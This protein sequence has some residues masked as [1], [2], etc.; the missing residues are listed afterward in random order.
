MSR[1]EVIHRLEGVHTMCAGFAPKQAVGEAI[2]AL[3]MEIKSIP[4]VPG[5]AQAGPMPWRLQIAATFAAA[6]C[7]N[8]SVPLESL[9]WDRYFI[10]ADALLAAEKGGA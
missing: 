7:P 6:E 8:F 2:A 4:D 3:L 10:M 1:A 5:D 9:V